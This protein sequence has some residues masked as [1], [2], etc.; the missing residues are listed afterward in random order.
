VDERRHLLRQLP[1]RLLRLDCNF[2][3]GLGVVLFPDHRHALSLRGLLFFAA[4]LAW[5]AGALRAAELQIDLRL[6]D[7]PAQDGATQAQVL[8]TTATGAATEPRQAAA[9]VPGTARFDVPAGSAWQVSVE[10]AGYWSRPEPV[11]VHPS[12]GRAAVDLLPAGRV[13]GVVRTPPDQKMPA[14]LTIRMRPAPGSPLEFPEV[15]QICRVE[16]GGRF[17]C[18]VPAGELDLR[19]RA[20]GF[21]THNRWGAKVPSGRAFDAGS[22]LLRPGASVVGWIPAPERDFRYQDCTVV[23]EPYRIGVPPSLA[24]HE[25]ASELGQ[26]ETVNARGYF[27]VTGVAPGSYQLTVRHPR[28]APA[29]VAPLDVHPGAETEIHSVVLRPAIDLE[30]RMDPARGPGG[31]RWHATLLRKG[32]NPSHLI[33]VQEGLASEEGVLRFPALAP[34]PYE[35]QVNT[36]QG[37]RWAFEEVEVRPG[38]A[39]HVVELPLLEVEGEV[40]L[41][42]E[43]LRSQVWFGG[44]FGAVRVPI[45][46]D[47]EGRFT[48]FVPQRDE[49]WR[50]EVVNVGAQIHAT[51]PGV[52][53]KKAP[54]QPAARVRLAVPDTAVRGEVV[55]EA[56]KPAAAR[57]RAVGPG[58]PPNVSSGEDGA[59]ELRGLAPGDWQLEASAGSREAGR[60]SAPVTVQVAEDRPVESLRLVL[61]PQVELAGQVV[62]PAGQ[63]IPGALVYA[64]PDQEEQLLTGRTPQATTDVSGTFRLRLP[65]G[66]GG[67]RLLVLAPGFALRQLRTD[68]RSKEPLI[69]SV[70]QVGGTV[71][72]AF[73]GGAEVPEVLKQ[74]GTSLFHD[75]LIP[76]DILRQWAE[77]QRAYQEPGRYVIPMLEPGPSTACYEVP[78]QAER[79]GRLP[80]EQAAV[81]G[82]TC[83]PMAGW[84]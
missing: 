15:S 37:T 33:T 77:A 57:I 40:L 35:I 26:K 4:L 25:R 20:R 82:A 7:G 45:E 69:V 51:F 53:V 56:G 18:V 48:T 46:T 54:G 73:E 6:P 47:E 60:Q 21:L 78:N 23:L 52:E 63:A 5:P 17:A 79:S 1:N 75:F 76:A 8:L 32:T 14:E 29:Q 72:V 50:V 22:L 39:P 80:A 27:E 62:G 31:E 10:A 67:T 16:E 81:C 59:F 55:D 43:P 34:G 71:A 44:V 66:A 58:T 64:F 13:Q 74:L 38:M 41:G 61:R 24:D 19:L 2:V 42:S 65:A 49:P 36:A 84:T 70:Q 11:V 30:V 83:R 3:H 12:G 9:A 68:A 28:Y